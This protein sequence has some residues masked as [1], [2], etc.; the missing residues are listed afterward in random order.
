MQQ[1]LQLLRDIKEKGTWKDPARK[2]MPR[3]LSLFGTRMELDMKDGFPLLTTKKVYFKGIMTELLWFLKGDT[4][5]KYLVDNGCHIWNQ[6]AYRWYLKKCEEQNIGRNIS[7]ELFVNYIKNSKSYDE[8]VLDSSKNSVVECPLTPK[9]YVLGDLG[10]VYGHQWRNQNGVDQ[11]VTVIERLIKEPE[12]RYAILDA[13]NPTD[14]NEMAL[15]P[16][17]ILYQFNCRKIDSYRREDLY[18]RKYN[19]N[20]EQRGEMNPNDSD[21]HVHIL[22]DEDNIP[23]Y[24]LDLQL[25]QRSCDTFLGVPF[26]VASGALLL[27][28]I[29]KI[30]GMEPGKFV[31]VGGDTHIYEN[32]L[33]AVEEQLSRTP[34]KLPQLHIN[35]FIECQGL[36]LLAPEFFKL[37]NYNPQA[38]IEAELKTGL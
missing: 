37:E 3:T 32:H 26:N 9:D 19:F 13:W 31:W 1:Y 2:N 38:K 33:E 34:T 24:Y 18:A 12:G 7:F 36:T 30:V 25:Y 16:C 28:I 8:L 17:H 11:L 29:S 22:M 35:Q 6:D 23:K 20:D 27:H 14:F 21:E 4:N 10:K 5:I 15:P